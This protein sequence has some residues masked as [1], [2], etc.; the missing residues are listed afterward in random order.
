MKPSVRPEVT[1]SVGRDVN[2]QVL[3]LQPCSAK[4]KAGVLCF[5]A[6]PST[7]TRGR[8]RR[9]SRWTT[10]RR[11]S[12][13]WWLRR[14]TAPWTDAPAPPPSPSTCWTW[15]TTCPSSCARST[16]PT[17]PRTTTMPWSPPSRSVARGEGGWVG[18][19]VVR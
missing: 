6:S 8:S 12:T 3:T 5:S 16:R 11:A 2:I 17:C 19:E 18:S 4:G 7:P 10:R 15:R 1:M 9:C 14:R 13:C